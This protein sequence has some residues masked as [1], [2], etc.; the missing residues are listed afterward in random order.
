MVQTVSRQS[1]KV[2]VWVPAPYLVHM[3]FVLEKSGTA[4]GFCSR[5]SVS[6]VSVFHL[7]S[8]LVFYLEDEIQAGWWPQFRVIMSLTD[9][10]SNNKI[11]LRILLKYLA[12]VS[13]IVL[14][15]VH[16]I[17]SEYSGC[18]D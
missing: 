17:Q 14:H 9:T 2:Q 8:V 15:F 6:P 12:S 11:L 5:C 10:K 3:R 18:C 13:Y 4:T 16:C 7:Y 1:L